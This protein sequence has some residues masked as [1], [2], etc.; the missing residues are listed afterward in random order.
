VFLTSASVAYVSGFALVGTALGATVAGLALLA[1]VTGFCM[2]CWMYKVAA[3][4]LG[5]R[6]RHFDAA[7]YCSECAVD[8]R[9]TPAGC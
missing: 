5:I 6:S 2:G 7:E 1:A 9:E 3:P 8:A 4:L